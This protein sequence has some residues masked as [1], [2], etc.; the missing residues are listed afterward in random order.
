MPPTSLYKYRSLD[1]AGARAFT[2]RTVKLGEVYLAPPDQFN[3]PFESRYLLS[4]DA[5]R[6]EKVDY[7]SKV[8][9]KMRR[10]PDSA[11]ARRLA[12][13]IA[14]EAGSEFAGLAE[15]GLID[16]LRSNLAVLALAEQPDNIL[17]W[18]HYGDSHRGVCLEFDTG[19][20]DTFKRAASVTYSSSVPVLRFFKDGPA[21]RFVTVALT[22][23]E[24][25]RYE[26]EWRV[27]DYGKG[28]GVRTI[29]PGALVGIV[30]GVATSP[31]DRAEV[32]SWV[33]GRP[34]RL[35]EAVLS[36]DRYTVSIQSLP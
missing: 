26:C 19:A 30:F 8:L 17:M 36:R 28:H 4:M 7:L 29:H 16:R 32:R 15:P 27:V 5:T 9:L 10:V 13:E 3:D 33:S 14:S 1:P 6:D 34:V 25:W 20:D 12:R 31:G 21:E 2:E 22:K 11:S 24:L 23:S 35:S 18:S